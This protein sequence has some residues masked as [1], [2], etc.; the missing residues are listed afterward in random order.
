MLAWYTQF[1]AGFG[2][3]CLRSGIMLTFE[4]VFETFADYLDEDK[5]GRA[6]V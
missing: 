3:I 6:H 1:I 4:R 5:I 2:E